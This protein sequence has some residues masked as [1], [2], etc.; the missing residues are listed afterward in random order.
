[1]QI[2]DKMITAAC[3]I[4]GGIEWTT[5][6]LRQEGNEIVGQ[7]NLPLP[8]TEQGKEAASLNNLELTPEANEKLEGDL[9]VSIRTSELL[10]RTV[11]FPTFDPVEIESMSDF[12]IDKVSPFPLDQL[13]VSYEILQETENGVLVLIVAVKHDYI[14]AIGDAFLQTGIHIHSIDARILG[15]FQLMKEGG[16]LADNGC[17]ILIVDD[18]IDF[19]LAVLFNGVPLA[20]RSLPSP[21]EYKNLVS[22]LTEEIGYTLTTLDTEYDLPPPEAINIWSLSELSETTRALLRAKSGLEI[23]Q[24]NLAALPPLS[25]GIISRT[26][27]IKHRIE[28]IPREW[29]EHQRIQRLKKKFL[30]ASSVMVAIWLVLLITLTSIYQTRAI[31]LKKVQKK[32]AALAPIASK[33]IENRKKLRALKNY[34]DRSDSALECLREVTALLPAGDIDFGKYG[35]DRKK[36]V[37]L[38]GTAESDDLVIEY[39]NALSDSPLFL[40]LKDQRTSTQNKKGDERAVYSATLTLPSEEDDQ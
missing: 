37:S 39:W 1:M 15:W 7:G 27:H 33:A 13:A 3:L 17:E 21:A 14:D 18:G 29:I 20:F 22:E 40:E 32:E 34:A 10:M 19:A 9:T 28:L 26:Q 36:G 5:L 24:H 6:K 2:R 23:R 8:A 25:E 35:Y 30:I 38:R 31:V 11:E 16:H 12:Q 4:P